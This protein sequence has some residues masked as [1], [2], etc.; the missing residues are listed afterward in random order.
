[1]RLTLIRHGETPANVMGSLDT[2][3]PGPGLTDRGREQAQALPDLLRELDGDPIDSIWVSGALRTHETAAPLAS[4]LGLLPT[5]LAGAH[6]I[7]AGE[8]EKHT[9]PESVQ[10]YLEVLWSWSQ[11][12]TG[13]R[14]PGAETG[15]EVLRRFDAGVEQIARSGTRHAVLVS[16]GA[17]I[18]TWTCIRS[19]NLGMN[20]ARH[21]PLA[22]TG[23]VVVEGEPAS[24]WVTRSWM[25]APLGGP[26]IDGNDPY[27]GPTGHP[28]EP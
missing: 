15:D 28:F 2:A 19:H 18:R 11:G 9:D 24:G 20:F 4:A 12:D 5:T 27:D 14:M 25:G 23:I 16:H 26:G 13:V 1:M 7:Q 22:N 21:N 17:M 3:L 6:E 8:V 10:R